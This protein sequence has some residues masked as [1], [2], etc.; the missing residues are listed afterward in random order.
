MSK[1]KTFPL[2]QKLIC[3]KHDIYVATCAIYHEQYVGQTK[4]KF[5]TVIAP[6]WLEQTQ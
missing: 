2:N 5:S 1:T 6:Q 3:A 4:N